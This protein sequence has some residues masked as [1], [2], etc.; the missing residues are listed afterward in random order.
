MSDTKFAQLIAAK[1]IDPRR[2]VAVSRS[3]ESLTVEDRTIRLTKRI[4]RKSEGGDKNKG[5]TKQVHSGRPLTPRALAAAITGVEKLSG[6]TKTRFLKAVNTIL[7]AKK[8]TVVS[9]KD[10]F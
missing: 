5:K 4:A 9:L 3:L 2:L 10:L 1:K 6:P 7:E 8:E